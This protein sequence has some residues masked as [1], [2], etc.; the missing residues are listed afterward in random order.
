MNLQQEGTETNSTRSD[1]HLPWWATIANTYT[2]FI[3]TERQGFK[4]SYK[5]TMTS[6]AY[7]FLWH[8]QNIK[9]VIKDTSLDMTIVFR[10]LPYG[11]F[12]K[13]KSNHREEKLPS[14]NQ[15]TDFLGDRFSER[16]IVRV[17][18]QLRRQRQS[19]HFKR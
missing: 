16:D 13:I 15:G 14:M 7:P 8:T 3:S 11:N 6:P 9:V 2:C 17:S 4:R 5:C 18:I 1:E 19:H 12:I 10:A